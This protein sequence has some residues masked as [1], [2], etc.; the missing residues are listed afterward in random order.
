VRGEEDWGDR[1]KTAV[2]LRTST[3]AQKEPHIGLL[4]P[5]SQRTQQLQRV[6][7]G[8]RW[9]FARP[10][11]RLAEAEETLGRAQRLP[12]ACRSPPRAEGASGAPSPAGAAASRG[13]QEPAP[14]PRPGPAG[15]VPSEEI[16][17]PG[18]RRPPP[19]E[20]LPVAAGSGSLAAVQRDADPGTG[21]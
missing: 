4:S 7:R 2:L 14:T 9:G 12:R 3:P 19:A 16:A 10:R 17:S 20:L 1:S 15:P 5:I 8:G 6:R 11:I 21:V 18:L 13:Q